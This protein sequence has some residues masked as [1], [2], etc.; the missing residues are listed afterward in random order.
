MNAIDSVKLAQFHRINSF[1]SFSLAE[2]V[3]DTT[4]FIQTNLLI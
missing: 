2:I 3:V 4:F 1:H